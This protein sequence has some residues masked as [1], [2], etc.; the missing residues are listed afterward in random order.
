MARHKVEETFEEP[1]TFVKLSHVLICYV[2]LPVAAFRPDLLP[3]AAYQYASHYNNLIRGLFYF[4]SIG[5]L[6]QSVTAMILCN[7]MDSS[8]ETARKWGISVILNG[9]FGFWLLLK[10]LYKYELMQDPKKSK[11]INLMN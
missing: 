6:L 8:I 5:N 3:F 7:Y 4:T 11:P 1:I 10:V 9:V 2:I